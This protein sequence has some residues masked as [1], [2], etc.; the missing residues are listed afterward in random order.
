MEGDI[1]MTYKKGQIVRLTKSFKNNQAGFLLTVRP[2]M[3]GV[4][5]NDTL[6]DAIYHHYYVDFDINP[7]TSITLRVPQ[8]YFEI[9]FDSELEGPNS[10]FD[11]YKG[12]L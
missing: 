1:R 5:S 10:I 6:L 7:Y 11:T 8:E 2:G 4:I 9:V 3:L 12:K